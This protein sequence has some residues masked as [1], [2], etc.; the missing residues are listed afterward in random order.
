MNVLVFMCDQMQKDALYDECSI[1]PNVDALRKEALT[2]DKAYAPNAVCS[3]SRASLMT[4]VY[5]S[6]H[7]VLF[8]THVA[9][10]DQAVLRDSYPHW[11]QLLQED[12]YKTGY[13]GKWHVERTNNLEAYG[14]EFNAELETDI[15]REKSGKDEAEINQ[16]AILYENLIGERYVTGDNGYAPF[17][18]YGHVDELPENREMGISGD[19]TREY[20]R[21]RIDGG[22]KWCTFVSFREPHDPYISSSEHYEMYKEKEITLTPDYEDDLSGKPGLYSKVAETWKDFSIDEKKEALRHYY[23]SITE[24][25]AELGKI[26]QLLKE[27]GQY[28]ETIIVILTDHGDNMGAHQLYCKNISAFEKIYNIPLIMRVPGSNVNGMRTKAMVNIVDLFPTILDLCKV[29]SKCK[30]D[31][32]SFSGLFEDLSL[33]ERFDGSY[34]QY[35]G[36][37]FYAMQHVLWKK[38]MKLVFNGFDYDELYDLDNDPYELNNLAQDKMHE[39]TYKRLHRQIWQKIKSVGYDKFYQSEYP[40]VRVGRFGPG[41]DY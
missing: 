30:T 19:I 10:D 36:G 14:W 31:G 3:P 22:D 7:G 39:D 15:Y 28:E 21:E 35:F 17:L 34:A 25:D 1:T 2:F 33:E 4:G 29:E 13:I 5:P 41:V 18:H 40:G 6:K 11:A 16:T 32:K 12:G 38:N 26:V 20:I 23:A 24:L 8:V 37:R 9:D 27:K